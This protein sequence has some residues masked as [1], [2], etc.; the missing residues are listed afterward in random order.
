MARSLWA[1]CSI[2]FIYFFVSWSLYL[3]C[4][5]LMQ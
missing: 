4:F 5:T 3:E 1:I 2:I